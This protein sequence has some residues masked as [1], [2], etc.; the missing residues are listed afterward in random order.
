M[1]CLNHRLGF[2]RE[3]A[4]LLGILI[5][6]ANYIEYAVNLV[7]SLVT[8]LFEYRSQ[9]VKQTQSFRAECHENRPLQVVTQLPFI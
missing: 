9:I 5:E 3:K 4:L 6:S 1:C 8:S 7:A 2:R